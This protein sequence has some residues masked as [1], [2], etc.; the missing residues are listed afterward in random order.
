MAS[1]IVSKR[2]VGQKN[3]KQI[4]PKKQLKKSE[5]SFTTSMPFIYT[6]NY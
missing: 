4:R 2:P 5:K 3:A 6:G 1:R